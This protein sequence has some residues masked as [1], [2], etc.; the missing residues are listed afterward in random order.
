MAFIGWP[1]AASVVLR[2]L[3]RRD[4]AE[5]IWVRLGSYDAVRKLGTPW[6]VRRW[7]IE[8]ISSAE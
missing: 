4:A 2:S 3:R 1:A 7:K 6:M 8:W 5:P